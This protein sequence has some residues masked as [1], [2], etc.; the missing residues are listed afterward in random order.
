MCCVF[1]FT[2][3]Y[4]DFACGIDLSTVDRWMDCRS[5][6][7]PV[8]LLDKIGAAVQQAKLGKLHQIHAGTFHGTW[9]AAPTDL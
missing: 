3:L 4:H 5:D 2:D 8:T 7:A 6:E 9:A 1:I